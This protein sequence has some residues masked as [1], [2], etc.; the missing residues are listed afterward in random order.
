[1][2]VDRREVLEQAPC[3]D[4]RGSAAGSPTDR[5][6]GLAGGSGRL[7]SCGLRAGEER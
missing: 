1:M 4:F 3:P 7:W 6:T 5:D 2:N